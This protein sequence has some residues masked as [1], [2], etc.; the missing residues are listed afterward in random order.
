MAVELEQVHVLVVDGQNMEILHSPVCRFN[1][2]A[3]PEEEPLY[4]C[5]VAWEED[6]FGLEAFFRTSASDFVPPK[7]ESRPLLITGRYFIERYLLAGGNHWAYPDAHD[8][9]LKL[10]YPEE[11]GND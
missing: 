3:S 2:D 11:G 8:S 9:G 6:E 7:F 10:N 4:S 1:K 5:G